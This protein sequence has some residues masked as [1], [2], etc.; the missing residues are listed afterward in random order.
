MSVVISDFRNAFPEF[1]DIAKYPDSMITFWGDLATAMVNPHRWGDQ[2]T[3]G[4][5]LYTA[6]EVTLASQN[7]QSG[8]VGG[9]PGGQSG[10]INSKT[11]GSVT[12]AYDTQQGAEKDAGYWN[13]TSFGK[14]FIRLAR[15]F[16]SGA[17]QIG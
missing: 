2:T 12:A 7:Y 3:V 6:H 9:T 10:P 8:N 13:L 4:I 16:G 17:V 11:V 15:I 1:Q 14:Q 5:F